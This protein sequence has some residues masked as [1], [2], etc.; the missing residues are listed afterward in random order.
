MIQQKE[1]KVLSY[2]LL[3]VTNEFSIQNIMLFLWFYI[4][5]ALATKWDSMLFVNTGFAKKVYI[6][7]KS[8]IY[9]F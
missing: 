5:S 7:V 4:I 3:F 8:R 2:M 6:F 9:S 1:S